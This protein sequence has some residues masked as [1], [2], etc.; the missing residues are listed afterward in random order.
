M[1]L[2]LIYSTA[3][4]SVGLRR[5]LDLCYWL[6]FHIFLGVQGVVLALFHSSHVFFTDRAVNLFNPAMINLLAVI[7]V[8]CS[9][10]YGRYLYGM[11]HDTRVDRIFRRWILFHR[12]LAACVYLIT[13][14]H[15]TLSYMFAPSLG[16]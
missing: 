11:L 8:F 14:V 3:R 5:V 10:V 12:P 13:I 6:H 2:L 9:G 7:V 4:R 16:R 15:V 1:A